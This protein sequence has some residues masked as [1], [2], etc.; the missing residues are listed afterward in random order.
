MVMDRAGAGQGR[1]RDNSK[2]LAGRNARSSSIIYPPQKEQATKG[3]R[4]KKC[5]Q[6]PSPFLTAVL[7]EGSLC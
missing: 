5:Q 2:C 7:M 1:V 6:N 4:L 3:H